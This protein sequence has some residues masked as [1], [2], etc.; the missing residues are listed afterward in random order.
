MEEKRRR[1]REEEKS[2]RACDRKEN[3]GA[4]QKGE[5]RETNRKTKR[6]GHTITMRRKKKE[7]ERCG[8]R[9]KGERGR[10]EREVSCRL[11]TR[12]GAG[13]VPE[14]LKSL[15]RNSAGGGSDQR[16][17]YDVQETSMVNKDREKRTGT[18]QGRREGG[19]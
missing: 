18:G 10:A 14:W 15:G 6:R 17:S 9:G 12:A 7:D 11:G 8:E 1:R 13:E 4:K 16:K 5:K 19:C 2:K 3:E